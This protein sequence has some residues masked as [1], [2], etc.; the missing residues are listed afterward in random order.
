MLFSIWLR[1][2]MLILVFGDMSYIPRLKYVFCEP[3]VYQIERHLPVNRIGTISKR[4]K[5]TKGV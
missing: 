4:V 5:A 1:S 2:H 3:K